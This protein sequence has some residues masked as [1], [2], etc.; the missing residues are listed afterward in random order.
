MKGTPRSIMLTCANSVAGWWTGGT[1]AAP[2]GA[3]GHA[4]EA[5]H[6]AEP[7]AKAPQTLRR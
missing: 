4:A 3:E 2:R 1:A 7:H 6:E 5:R